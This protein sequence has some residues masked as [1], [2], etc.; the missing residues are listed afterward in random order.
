MS[1]RATRLPGSRVVVEPYR[2]AVVGGP[3]PGAPQPDAA[4]ESRPDQSAIER[5]AFLKGYAQG[6]RAGGDAAAKRG[7][8]MLRRLKETLDELAALRAEILHRSERE[9]V[10]LALS[11]AQRIVQREVSLDRSLLVGMA[12]AALDRLADF[13]SAT[14]RLHPDDYA[15]VAASLTAPDGASHVQIAADPAVSRGGCLVQSN[16]GFMDVSHQAQFDEL[17]RAILEGSEPA[18]TTSGAGHGHHS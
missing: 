6:E 11:I 12:R 3:A 4:A 18:L 17:A 16:F 10:Q 1:S 8:G 5:D 9:T 7:E 2:W 14:I 15:A 13:S